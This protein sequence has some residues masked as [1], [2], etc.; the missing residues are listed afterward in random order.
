MINNSESYKRHVCGTSFRGN[1]RRDRKR[2]KD[3]ER[4]NKKKYPPYDN[5]EWCNICQMYSDTSVDY[6]TCQCS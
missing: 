5:M 2:E 4:L 3:R 6:G 1:G